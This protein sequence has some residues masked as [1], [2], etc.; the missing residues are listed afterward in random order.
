MHTLVSDLQVPQQWGQLAVRVE[1]D[2]EVDVALGAK[3]LWLRG[4]SAA[5]GGPNAGRDSAVNFIFRNGELFWAF[6]KWHRMGPKQCKNH[7]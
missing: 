4:W 7:S 6:Q 5:I 2:E 1:F 3:H